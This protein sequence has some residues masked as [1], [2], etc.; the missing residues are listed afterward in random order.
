MAGAAG[1]IQK[2]CMD[3]VLIMKEVVKEAPDA[4]LK[5][6][7]N[8]VSAGIVRELS[9]AIEKEKLENNVMYCGYV[10]ENIAEVYSNA[11]VFW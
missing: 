8:E 7:G 2:Q 1:K 11:S 6:Y 9:K 5:I 3:I 10:N 4:V